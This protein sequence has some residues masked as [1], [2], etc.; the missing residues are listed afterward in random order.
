M[1]LTIGQTIQQLQRALQEYIEATYHI[2]HPILVEQRRRLLEEPGVIHQ[3]PYLESTPRYK[4]GKTFRSLG[5]DEAALEV[6]SV[7]SKPLGDLGVLIH[8][9]PYEHQADSTRLSLVD[10][11]S[12]VVMTGTGSG[13]TECFLLPI[14]GKL[15]KEAKRS[16]ANFKKTNAVR[17]IV[18][19]P[20]NALVND[21]LGR[22]RLL[23]GDP[24]I[25]QKFV[26]WSGRP[27]RFAR[28]TSRTLYPGVR[29]EQKDKDRLAPIQ[30][31]YV[32]NM[33]LA[34]G[35]SS[36]Q[37]TA[38]KGLVCELKK[39][40]KWPAKPDLIS[41]YGKSGA[42]W[43]DSKS[44]AFKRCVTLPEDSEL[45]TRHEVQKSPPDV[46]VTN[47]SMLE[48]M[49]MRPLER[50]IFDQTRDWLHSNPNENFLLVIDE[51][52]LYRGSGG[53]EVALLIRRLR[54]RLG[55][56]TERFQVICTSASFNSPDNAVNF[57][58]QL[59][60]KDP[61]D[62]VKVE[63]EL[64][65]RDG[66]AKGTAQD[67]NTLNT[68]DV[69][70]LYDSVDDAKLGQVEEFLKYRG[71]KS[72]RQLQQALYDALV[73]YPPMAKLINI[74]MKEAQ[75]VDELGQLIFTN[76][77]SED[78]AH[79]VANLIALG[80]MA[81][82]DSNEPGLLPCRVHSFYRGLAGLWACMDP[83]CSSLPV[84][85]RGGPAGKLFSQ[86]R[87]RCECGARV[88]E[89]F[90]CRNCG[91][92]YGRA[93]TN[94]IAYPNYLWAEPGGAFRT[95]SR[96]F[97]E[98][99]PIDLLLEKPTQYDTV[100][101]AEYDLITGRLNP[102]NLGSRNRQ[103]YLR[104]ERSQP[105]NKDEVSLNTSPGEFRPCAVCGEQAAYGHSSVQD[106][107]TKGD[108]P[109]RALIT[110][111]IQVQ[112]PSSPEVTRLAPLRGRK[113]L[114]F[115]DSRQT[116]A[117]LAP[118]LQKY[119]TQ[120]SLRPLILY[121]FAR[122]A[123]V[124]I[125]AESLSLD[126]LYL[127]VLIASKELG[128]RLRPELMVGES[129]QEEMIIEEASR[130]GSLSNDQ[131]LHSL[132]VQ[133]RASRPPES[134]IRSIFTTVVDR[135]Y[136]FESLALAS[137]IE[138]FDHSS[139]IEKLPDITRFVQSADEKKALTRAW[140]RCWNGVGIWLSHMPPAWW[141]ESRSFRPS[142]GKFKPISMLVSDRPA[143]KIFE[144]DWLPRLLSIFT[145]KMGSG[146]FRL[147]GSELSLEIG[148]SWVYCHSCRTTQRPF[149]G[150][151]I[152]VNCGNETALPVNPETDPVFVAR[153]GYY[154]TSTINAFKK[155]PI[156]PMALIAAEHTAQLNAAQ[157]DEI[158]S[159]AEEHELLF[160][161]VN[162]GPDETGR[163]RPAIDV[164]SCTT[165][166][167]V[168]IDIGTL[169]GVSLRN[170][171]PT[172]ANYQQ[173]SGRA[174]RRGNAV[175]TVTAFGSADSYDE[176]YFTCPDQ[177]IRGT[178]IDPSLTLD[179]PEIAR[180]HVT[181]YLLQRYHH[182]K[183]PEIKPEAQPS[184][185]A[186]LGSVSDFKDP[187]KIL[188]RTDF[189]RWL[190]SN[191]IN[192]KADVRAW[193]PNEISAIERESI[194]NEIVSDTL[195]PID[196]AIDYNPSNPSPD[197][198][199]NIDKSGNEI[200]LETTN[201]ETQDQE[202][203]ER[204]AYD[205]ASENLLDRLLYKGVLPRYAFPTDV[206]AFHVFDI[207]RS[208][209]YR[210]AFRF[211]PSQGLPIALSQYAPGKDV[212]IGNKLW[213]SGAIY[214]P[215]R[216]DIFHAWQTR[217][218]YCECKNCHYARTMKLEEGSRGEARDCEACGGIGT[219]G[220]AT[221]WLRPPG[222]AHPVSKTEGTSPDDHPANSYAT[223]AKLTMPSPTD[224]GKWTPLNNRLRIFYTRQHLLVTNR[225]PRQEG[226]TYCTKC[227]LIEPSAIPKGIVGAAHRKPFPDKNDGNCPGGGATKGLV[228][229][230]DFISDIL[231]LSIS[232]NPPLTLAPTLLATDIVLRTISEA[233][234][235][236]ACAI[237]GLESRELQAEYRPALTAEGRNGLEAEIF[238]YDTLPGGAGFSK[239]VGG[240]G[241]AVLEEALRVLENCPDNCDRSCYRCLRSY[242]NKFEH[243]L[244]DRHIGSCLLRYL[245]F[246]T[247]PTFDK[248]RLN[249]S[250]DILFEDLLRQNLE[251]TVI[252]RNRVLRLPGFGDIT[253]PIYAKR[254]DS[255][256]FIIGIHGPLTPD[257]PSDSIL[258][259]IKEF[260][261]SI[262]VLL[263]DELVIRRNLPAET[264]ALLSI[265]G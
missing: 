58:A 2:S 85:Q 241:I 79:A 165:T 216:D 76:A 20:M 257:Y 4:T 8:D 213:T 36:P 228:L 152:C 53:A 97:T 206:A 193:L 248:N 127:S 227:G 61:A 243:D 246:G 10:G 259:E 177:M 262:T 91:T 222:F 226:Y 1:S 51:A 121:G 185:F 218:L 110:K 111:Q 153:K 176:H 135:Y 154:R 43:K 140:L 191:E 158:F 89:L 98:L 184:L 150:R 142:S 247:Y 146:M 238:F 109:F 67:V 202:G 56:P 81:R 155:P 93:Y 249:V 207:D 223:R 200:E 240:L 65:L 66:E 124:P 60:G 233:L 178:V 100:E 42:R 22:L 102:R 104:K 11:R 122:L 96:E 38:A 132:W 7:V 205:P 242:K 139:K 187:N 62:F 251:N 74:T 29:T 118:N 72:S 215:I 260:C 172:R 168:G 108:E 68:F 107:Q 224:K 186:V 13:K 231:L 15:A 92:A 198:K 204:P 77:P 169:S 5:L 99:A 88:L 210:P 173:R 119:S 9:P 164:L 125:I 14:L 21:Q 151:T 170:M 117:R 105:S 217:R 147:R 27:A 31:Y 32:R 203:E 189:E 192:L 114:I 236:A 181:A 12:L 250:T 225:G 175:A 237:L 156:T 160:Q 78:A 190:R 195:M 120:D 40:G 141:G 174:G 47:Y 197:R 41:W 50:P 83:E 258:R 232:V 179:N 17:A 255:S 256:E 167:E 6:F 3:R 116:A 84:S 70:K 48:Y 199:S 263:R 103:V 219:F 162:L 52:H 94:D 64:L 234:S 26:E 131:K 239:R 90:T 112:S 209:I 28:Y 16:S 35:P 128:V 126:D 54:M 201:L 30:K 196:K 188:N 101:P 261:P 182:A 130:N 265:I 149:P 57:G 208:T 214:S 44:G 129:F 49:L 63:G 71:I 148:G 46:L 143:Q 34:D 134:L 75:P 115:S 106:H 264:S 82:K 45:F 211:T 144:K 235:K 137:F 194:L 183:L 221:Y 230:T 113:V 24:R 95:I 87:D 244:L 86:P 161:D 37:Q 245:I 166:M 159:K 33:E 80:S 39:R 171:P 123:R 145:E 252:E 18:L 157:A 19:Y 55:I 253:A 229:G 163:E 23:F 220:P 59:T 133:M 69:D 73:T 212:W 180:R 138:R 136:G 254:A 25:I